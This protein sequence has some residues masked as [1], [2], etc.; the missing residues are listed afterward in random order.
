MYTYYY[1]PI[2][3]QG[4]VNIEQIEGKGMGLMWRED[5]MKEFQLYDMNKLSAFLKSNR[6][7]IRGFLNTVS[8]KESWEKLVESK[9]SCLYEDQRVMCGLLSLVRC[10][11]LFS[12]FSMR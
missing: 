5:V 12:L 2:S 9:F 4:I 10:L 8:R 6:N 11:L 7:T 1:L 3:P